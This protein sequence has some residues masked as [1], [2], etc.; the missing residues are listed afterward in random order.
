MRIYI[1]ERDLTADVPPQD[2]LRAELVQTV[3]MVNLLLGGWYEPPTH[4][5]LHLST[6]VQ[7]VL[8]LIAQ[9][10][11]VRPIEA[12]RALCQGGAFRFV[13]ERMFAK[14]L[15]SLGEHDL[16]VQSPDGTL[17]LG[18]R[19]ERTVGHYSFFTAFMTP[20]EYRLVAEGRTLGTIPIDFPVGEGTYLIFAGR[21]WRVVSVDAE[22]RVI[23]LV[24]SVGGLVPRFTGSGGGVHDRVRQEMLR[25]YTSEDV[26]TFLDT[27][28]R[29]LLLEGRE[30]FARFGLGR[31]SLIEHGGDTLLFCWMGDRVMDTLLVILRQR[32]LKV[33]RDGLA[34]TIE[35]RSRVEVAEHL[36][37]IISTPPVD[38]R[39]LAV[40]VANKRTEKYHAFLTEEL[41]SADYAS[42]RLN[43]EGAWTSM[44]RILPHEML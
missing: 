9:H 33:Q 21:R 22:H 42:Q 27:T 40:T 26:P 8:S 7:Q 41:L 34:L 28:A 43:P 11:G 24:P 19:G 31:R 6:L 12:W 2:A 13:D 36:R 15:R 30:H 5:A 20:D 35:S 1:Q 23:D 44:Q 18:I 14:F 29:D 37:S 17:L 3:G 38:A 25:I 10:G 4:G 16:V 39:A 32:G